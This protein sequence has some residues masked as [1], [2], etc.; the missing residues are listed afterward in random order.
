MAKLTLDRDV[1]GIWTV[2]EETASPDAVVAQRP[3][4][5]VA[6]LLGMTAASPPSPIPQTLCPFTVSYLQI[7]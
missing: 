3:R 6:T 4:S 1:S 2:V 7:T 5:L